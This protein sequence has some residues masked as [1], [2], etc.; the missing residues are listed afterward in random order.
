[1]QPESVPEYD[2]ESLRQIMEKKS[3]RPVSIEEAAKVG[4]DL[5]ELFTAFLSDD[6]EVRREP[7]WVALNQRMDED[8]VSLAFV[9]SSKSPRKTGMYIETATEEIILNPNNELLWSSKWR[10]AGLELRLQRWKQI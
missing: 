6:V 8:V 10:E 5:I 2:Y 1:M 9:S 4:D 7:D 3:G